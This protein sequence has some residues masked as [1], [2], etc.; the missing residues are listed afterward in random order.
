MGGPGARDGPAVRMKLC[1]ECEGEFPDELS[2]CPSD[3]EALIQLPPRDDLVGEVLDGRYRLEERIGSGGMGAVYR[4]IQEP[5]GRAVAVKVLRQELASDKSV[6]ARFFNEARVISGLRHANTV[7]LYDFGQSASGRLYIAMEYLRGEPLDIV[8]ARGRLRL[9]EIVEIVDQVCQSIEEAHG[10]GIIHRD[11][12]PDNVFIDRVGPRSIVK[13][14]DF[15]IAKVPDPQGYVTQTGTVFGTPAYMSP[16]QAQGFELD[17][18]SD[19]YALGVVLY[20][21]ITGAPPFRGSSPVR[22]ALK[23]VTEIPSPVADHSRVGAL[24]P[25]LAELVMQMLAKRADDRPATITEVRERLVAVARNLPGLVVEAPSPTHD[26]PSVRVAL[27][28]EEFGLA[29]DAGDAGP[30]RPD[31]DGG[32]TLYE[33]W[34]AGDD[35]AGDS[36]DHEGSENAGETAFFDSLAVAR[37][38]DDDATRIVPPAIGR[39]GAR[40]RTAPA[41]VLAVA[42]L[43]AAG[44]ALAVVS[45]GGDGAAGGAGAGS[46]VG[47]TRAPESG[48]G[49]E[50][51]ATASRATEDASDAEPA[52]PAPIAEVDWLAEGA[53]RLAEAVDAA[54]LRERVVRATRGVAAAAA[55]AAAEQERAEEQARAAV[56]PRRERT[57]RT[58]RERPRA[59]EVPEAPEA[60]ETGGDGDGQAIAP[61]D[62]PR[63]RR[64]P[65]QLQPPV[66]LPDP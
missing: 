49:A 23:H 61:I 44:V 24:P 20:E 22:V 4:G 11:L 38:A 7:T 39:G 56:E 36:G 59:P 3:G 16:E 35:D 50:A 63:P 48:A 31:P 9:A 6:V 8:L 17:V 30:T 52:P 57:P 64:I 65:V 27:G 54:R 13:V 28:A 21:M 58:G 29:S 5:V 40:R 34:R 51:E 45:L 60:P 37:A 25:A 47:A 10:L 18:R 55:A 53:G 26:M 1:P 15:G 66:T 41:A 14:L 32:A 46:E 43:V 19:I 2:R 62:G 42:L 33:P 12:K